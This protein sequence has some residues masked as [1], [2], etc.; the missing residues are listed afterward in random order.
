MTEYVNIPTYLKMILQKG[1]KNEYITVDV[2]T[3]RGI[4]FV[5]YLVGR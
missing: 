2:Q 5:R 1:L 3:L 4:Q